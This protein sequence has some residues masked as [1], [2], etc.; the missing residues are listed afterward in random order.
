MRRRQKKFSSDAGVQYPSKK[1][2]SMGS[3]SSDP[4]S[5]PITERITRE[6]ATDV[7]RPVVTYL[8]PAGTYSH[9]VS[10]SSHLNPLSTGTGPEPS[11]TGRL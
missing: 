11:P 9:Q 5:D 6:Q 8:G 2:T 4:I 1:E 7:V 3:V 10:Q